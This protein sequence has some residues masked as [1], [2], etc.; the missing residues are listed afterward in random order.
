MKKNILI[1]T[2]HLILFV[3]FSFSHSSHAADLSD[4]DKCMLGLM[5]TAG[6]EM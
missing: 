4:M 5:Q 6:D 1:Y 2:V 3:G